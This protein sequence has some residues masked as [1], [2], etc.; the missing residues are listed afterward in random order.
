MLERVSGEPRLGVEVEDVSG[1]GR[2]EVE[3]EGWE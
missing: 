3:G 1:G 2:V